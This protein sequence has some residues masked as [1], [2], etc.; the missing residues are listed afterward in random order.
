M[1]KCFLTY[2]DDML[3]KSCYGCN[4]TLPTE[5]FGVSK[6]KIKARCKSCENAKNRN[7]CNRPENKSRVQ[8]KNNER[9]RIKREN[10]KKA[11]T[12]EIN[13]ESFPRFHNVHGEEYKSCHIC[14]QTL[15]ISEFDKRAAGYCSNCRKIK[16]KNKY[17]E[18]DN[19]RQKFLQTCKLRQQKIYADEEKHNEFRMKNN[20][21]KRQNKDILNE[22]SR[23][24]RSKL[25]VEERKDEVLRHSHGISYK[26]YINMLEACNFKCMI[27][28][29]EVKAIS[30]DYSTKACVDHCHSMD[31]IRGILCKDCNSGLG[32]FKDN[33]DSLSQ[34]LEYLRA[35]YND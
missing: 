30:S 26:E 13:R 33:I 8:Q 11:P 6:G 28:K 24:R 16:T 23:K 12:I 21:W 34:A 17:H 18:D 7:W 2:L 5:F 32:Y 10:N 9:R 19:F 31:K 29:R 3:Y 25:S 35:F 1:S 4:Q 20:A 14:M 27:C 22:K 15:P